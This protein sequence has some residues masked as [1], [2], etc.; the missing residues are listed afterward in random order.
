MMCI[1]L[2]RQKEEKYLNEA[3]I[4]AAGRGERMCSLH[5]KEICKANVKCYGNPLIMYVLFALEEANIKKCFVVLNRKHTLEKK[6]ERYIAPLKMEIIYIYEDVQEGSLVSFSKALDY[7]SNSFLLLDC[8]LYMKNDV[9]TKFCKVVKKNELSDVY[10][11]I[12]PNILFKTKNM[13]CLEDGN[14]IF[15]KAGGK[16]TVYG[17]MIYYFNYNCTS[18]V[19]ED[20]HIGETSFSS[21]FNK[22]SKKRKVNAI[23]VDNCWDNNTEKDIMFTEKYLVETT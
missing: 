18:D 4:L 19:L 16:N 8:D 5:N 7:V 21:F 6:L 23:E 12:M 2:K 17:G 15:E 1:E 14:Y 11:A 13:R 3:I 9:I 10:F 20:I 22:I